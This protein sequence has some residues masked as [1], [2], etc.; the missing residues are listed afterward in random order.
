MRKKIQCIIQYSL[1]TLIL[2]HLT[3][4]AFSLRNRN[5]LPPQL[6]TLYYKADDP[7][8]QFESV[9]YS[10]LKSSGINFV[11]TQM[12]AP[13]TLHVKKPDLVYT[14]GTIGTSNQTRVYV[15]TFTVTIILENAM[16]APLLSPMVFSESRNLV[17]S[18]NQLIKS[19]NQLS[20]LQQEMYRDIV[21]QLYNRFSS[22]QVAQVLGNRP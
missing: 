5:E 7:Y 13:V 9:L 8:G 3:A 16:G 2:I 22:E 17:L 12:Q 1:L 14:A 20:Q 19:N 4:C 21:S 10:S 6:H 11:D 18:A 15:V